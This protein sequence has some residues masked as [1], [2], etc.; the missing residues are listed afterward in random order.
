[1]VGVPII[2]GAD[3][4][5]HLHLVQAVGAALQIGAEDLRTALKQRPSLFRPMGLYIQALIIHV[6]Q[7]A[8][9][10]I[11][12]TIE[13]RLARWLLLMQDRAGSTELLMTHE[14][15]SAMLGAHR[16]GVTLAMHVLEGTGAILN[17]RGLITVLDRDK[18]LELAG[19][20]YQVTEDEYNR[21][22]TQPHAGS[23]TAEM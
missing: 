18:L 9:A 4:D 19:D 23:G 11:A 13:G 6:G 10:N 14:F 1:M 20:S 3:R 2:L 22:M 8:Y 17:Q 16:P 5:P 15:L 7:T 21:L 12:F